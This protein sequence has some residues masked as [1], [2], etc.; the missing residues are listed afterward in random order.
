[1]KFNKAKLTK[2]MITMS[3]VAGQASV[4]LASTGGA[5]KFP[6]KVVKAVNNILGGV[7]VV[8]VIVAAGMILYAGFKFLTAGAGE[9]A[10]AKSILVPMAVGGILVALAG[11]IATWVWGLVNT[12]SAETVSLQ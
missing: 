9:K 3:L 11:P 12:N 1:M 2:A 6:S 8:G 5:G 4:A 7:S 10:K